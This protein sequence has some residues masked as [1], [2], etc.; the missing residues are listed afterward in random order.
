LKSRE[1]L[2]DQNANDIHRD[3]TGLQILIDL[4][5]LNEGLL[6][7]LFNDFILNDIVVNLYVSRDVSPEL[8]DKGVYV[9]P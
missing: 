8:V 9:F 1:S 6:S 3:Q 2:N 7:L 4:V 5:R